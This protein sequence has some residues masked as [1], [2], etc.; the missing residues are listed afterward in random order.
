METL[1]SSGEK[2]AERSLRERLDFATDTLLPGPGYNLTLEGLQAPKLTLKELS[3]YF[4]VELDQTGSAVVSLGYD[5]IN[6][7]LALNQVSFPIKGSD[8]IAQLISLK[9]GRY[10]SE[11]E[12]F[13][14]ELAKD[15]IT[16]TE[17]QSAI[18]F[19]QAEQ[20][21]QAFGITRA[22]LDNA[23][24]YREW[25]DNILEQSS[26]W[27]LVETLE[28]SDAVTDSAVQYTTLRREDAL[29]LQRERMMDLR[30]FTRTI[31]QYD[32]K[33][34]AQHFTEQTL[35]SVQGTNSKNV[36]LFLSSYSKKPD[37]IFGNL[38]DNCSEPQL[39]A[40]Q[41]NHDSYEEYSVALE[42]VIADL[43]FKS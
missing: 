38:K 24:S 9:S 3:A 35:E 36:R 30:Q 18:D 39:T 17:K 7:S 29:S 22:P 25:R 6:N 34:A 43:Y 27:H 12:A 32:K 10:I 5:A 26:G 8:K 40:I 1:L 11:I 21:L 31:V 15:G 2:F 13:V 4:G 19:E 23:A 16:A 41:L 37:I 14:P 20:L 33:T 42:K 28:I